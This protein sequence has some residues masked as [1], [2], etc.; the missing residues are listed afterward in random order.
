MA[1]VFRLDDGVKPPPASERIV[2]EALSRLP[3]EWHVFHSVRWQSLRNGRQGDGEA[4]FVLVHRQ[5]GI[6]VLEVK[7]ARSESS[8]VVGFRSID[9]GVSMKSA[10]LSRKPLTRSMR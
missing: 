8:V 1:Q 6:L 4:D 5:R 3:D 2:L 10:I 7:G 9:K